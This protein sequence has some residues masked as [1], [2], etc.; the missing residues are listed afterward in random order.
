M[1]DFA[2][3]PGIGLKSPC[4]R[5]HESLGPSIVLG[6]SSEHIQASKRRRATAHRPP[7]NRSMTCSSK[8][9]QLVRLDITETNQILDILEEWNKALE[10]VQ[11]ALEPDL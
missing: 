5:P 7:R 6:Q 3:A 1:V 9:L 2:V 10:A 4:P 11:P 8:R